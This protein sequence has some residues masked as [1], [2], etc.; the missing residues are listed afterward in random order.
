MVPS[1]SMDKTQVKVRLPQKLYQ[2]L[3]RR[4]I[5]E[6]RSMNWLANQAITDF[7]KKGTKGR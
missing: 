2:Q 3:K 4:A 5:K 6:D 1:W 7:L